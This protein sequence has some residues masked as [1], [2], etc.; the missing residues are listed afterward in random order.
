MA[1]EDD[2]DRLRTEMEELFADLCQVPRLV[3]PRRG[4]RPRVDVYRTEEPSAITV[5]VEL[6]GIDPDEIELAVADGALVVRGKRTRHAAHG[7]TY[8]HM[9]IDYGPFERRIALPE[10]VDAESADANYDRGLLS[11]RLPLTKRASGRVRVSVT[12]EQG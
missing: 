4:F 8:Q 10:P 12:R 6:A 7:R 2:L 3:A 5:V 9:E 1:R 11:I